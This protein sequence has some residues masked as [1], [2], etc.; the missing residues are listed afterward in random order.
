M[1]VYINEHEKYKVKKVPIKRGCS[2][3]RC[4]CTGKYEEIVDWRDADINNIFIIDYI[5]PIEI[6]EEVK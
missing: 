4:F 2:N 1:A 6:K 3:E 5:E